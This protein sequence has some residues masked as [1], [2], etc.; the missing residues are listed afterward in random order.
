MR[1]AKGFY[2]MYAAL[3]A[4]A[5]TIVLIPGSP[6]GLITVGVQVLAG[7]LLP[8]AT[9]F[10]LLLCN[11]KEV[12]GPWVNGVKTNIAGG[13]VVAILVILSA[14]LM[15][16]VVFGRV[17]LGQVLGIMGVSAIAAV[18]AGGLVFMRAWLVRRRGTRGRDAGALPAGRPGDRKE[19]RENWR[20]PP[21]AML[22]PVQ[23][24][25]ARRVGM[26]AMYVYLGAAIILVIVRVAQIAIGG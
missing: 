24:S 23:M 17:S 25:M 26:S 7:V 12:L 22:A 19:S 9:V 18:L 15:I 10:L 14:I 20:M 13:I 6:L 5:A 16:S 1:Q 11:D 2:A 21:L 8:S 4:L 3:I